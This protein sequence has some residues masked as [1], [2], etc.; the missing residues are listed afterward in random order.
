MAS[1]NSHP[2]TQPMGQAIHDIPIADSS[3]LQNIKYDPVTYQMTVTMKNG[4]QYVHFY[5]YPQTFQQLMESPSKGKFY[6]QA[7]KGK[8]PASKVVIKNIGP[9]VR[10]PLKGPLPHERRIT[11]SIARNKD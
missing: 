5:V 4:A 3:F 8:N 11:K 9:Q 2:A 10:N 1:I 6:A 7:I